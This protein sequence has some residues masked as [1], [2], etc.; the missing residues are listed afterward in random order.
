MF[1]ACCCME[2]GSSVRLAAFALMLWQSA[3]MR[4]Q[5]S[6]FVLEVPVTKTSTQ[7]T[8]LINI[9]GTKF[10]GNIPL[11]DLLCHLDLFVASFVQFNCTNNSSD[12]FGPNHVM[13]FDRQVLV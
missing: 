12:V 13:Q 11:D 2:Q 4:Q 10:N 5:A 9:E 3:I 8:K 1:V 7:Q 6:R